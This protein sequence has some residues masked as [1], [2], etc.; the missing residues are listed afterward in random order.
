MPACQDKS[1]EELRYE[2]Y[3]KDNKDM[4]PRSPSFSHIDFAKV[5]ELSA[6]VAKFF[7]THVT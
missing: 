5:A 7:P 1:F 6:K 3:A 2:D 4:A